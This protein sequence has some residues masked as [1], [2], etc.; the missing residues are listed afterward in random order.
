MPDLF[1]NPAAFAPFYTERIAYRGRSPA[2]RHIAATLDA[3]VLDCGYA[4][5]VEGGD[6]SAIGTVEV[7]F[8]ESSWTFAESP[9]KGDCVE[10]AMGAYCVQSVSRRFGEW[11]LRAKE[12]RAA[13]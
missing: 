8:P 12:V 13:C 10:C 9:Q 7:S 4:D 1:D 5:P 6:D 11:T 2:R 3:N